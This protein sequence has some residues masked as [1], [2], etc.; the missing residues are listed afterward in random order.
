ME[1]I[2]KCEVGDAKLCAKMIDIMKGQQYRNM[3]PHY[4]EAELRHLGDAYCRRRQSSA[5]STRCAMM[6]ALS[7]PKTAP[8]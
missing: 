1:S 6:S 8:S 3:S 5:C 2:E 4:L 7:T